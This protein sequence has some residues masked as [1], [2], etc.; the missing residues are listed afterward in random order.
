MFT[1]SAVLPSAGLLR[2]C[3]AWDERSVLNGQ[4]RFQDNMPHCESNASSARPEF[5]ELSRVEPR[6]G[7]EGG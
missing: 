3:G 2:P 5:S 6:T 7:P 4:A 1:T